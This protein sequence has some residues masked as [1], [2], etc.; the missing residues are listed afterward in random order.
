MSKYSALIVFTLLFTSCKTAENTKRAAEPAAE[1]T[2]AFGSCNKHTLKNRLWD[3]IIQSRPDIWI[4]GGDN[5]YADTDDIAVISAMYEAQKNIEG[6]RKLRTEV[7]VIGT[8]DDH[9]YGINDGG[10]EWLAKDGSQE[11]F[12]DFMDIPHN[13][14][15][16]KQK[17]IYTSYD[18]ELPEGLVKIILLDTR[19]FRGP[20]TPDPSG[21]NRYVP[22]TFGNGAILGEVQ[23]QWLESEL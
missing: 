13:S 19:Y 7:P 17:G 15:K 21:N 2:I 12:L 5:I 9:D 3:D 16:R 8:W 4:W 10:E 18:Y 23:W 6:Y 11:A 1:F 22:N 20:L 14:P